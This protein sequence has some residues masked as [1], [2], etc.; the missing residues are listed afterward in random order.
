MLVIGMLWLL[1]T[2]TRVET[3]P[4]EEVEYTDWVKFVTPEEAVKELEKVRFADSFTMNKDLNGSCD[5]TL[6]AVEA[7]DEPLIC[8]LTALKERCNSIDDCLVYCIGNNVG[9]GIGGGCAHLCNYGW[10]KEWTDPES[11]KN[12]GYEW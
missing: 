6:L 9:Y 4:Y 1:S 10:R 11:A 12:C 7:D 8:Y 5:Y 2:I 3:D